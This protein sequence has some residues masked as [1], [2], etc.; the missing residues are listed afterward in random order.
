VAGDI[1]ELRQE[2]QKP[3]GQGIGREGIMEIRKYNLLR[4]G[5]YQYEVLPSELVALAARLDRDRRERLNNMSRKWDRVIICG[6][7]PALAY[8]TGHVIWWVVR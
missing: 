8:I 4:M 7:I 5:K 6:L 1:F 2:K 3:D